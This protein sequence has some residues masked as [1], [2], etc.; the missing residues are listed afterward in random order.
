MQPI[1]VMGSCVWMLRPISH[2]IV[3]TLW[4]RLKLSLNVL[5]TESPAVRHCMPYGVTVTRQEKFSI[6]RK[7][8]LITAS[9][10]KTSRENWSKR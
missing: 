7:L 4:I 1:V 6:D 5:R 9:L 2:K 3:R 10:T 8:E